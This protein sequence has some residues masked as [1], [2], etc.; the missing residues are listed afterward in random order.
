MLSA[1]DIVSVVIAVVAFA[2]L[3][4]FIEGLERT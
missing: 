3:F 1:M 2:A 4:A